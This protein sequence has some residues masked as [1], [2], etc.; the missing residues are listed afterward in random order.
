MMNDLLT[1]LPFHS[2]SLQAAHLVPPVPAA[3][4]GPMALQAQLAHPV[5]VCPV[6]RVE[7]NV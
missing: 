5:P 1:S 7:T 4:W 2:Q 3:G 6:G